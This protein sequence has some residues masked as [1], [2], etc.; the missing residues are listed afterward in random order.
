MSVLRELGTYR[1][2]V[3]VISK[4]FEIQT[5]HIL[6]N[7][8]TNVAKSLV[9]TLSL[10]GNDYRVRYETMTEII[11]ATLGDKVLETL[12]VVTERKMKEKMNR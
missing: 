8:R 6:Y 5:L 2:S 11:R 12:L 9:R 4:S 1:F 10:S 7:L 3:F